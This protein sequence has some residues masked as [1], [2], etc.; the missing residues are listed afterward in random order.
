MYI[1]DDCG[2]EFMVYEDK[3]TEMVYYCDKHKE[4]KD[5]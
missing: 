4:S 2:C 1:R 3:P 5:K